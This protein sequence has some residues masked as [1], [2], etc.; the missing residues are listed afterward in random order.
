MECGR[1]DE[2]IVGRCGSGMNKGKDLLTKLYFFN[3]LINLR[4]SWILITRV[5]L[6]RAPVRQ[7]YSGE[8]TGELWSL[9]HQFYQNNR[10]LESIR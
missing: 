4:L 9:F 3:Y 8:L 7:W 5:S 10:H 6:L 1:S 2:I